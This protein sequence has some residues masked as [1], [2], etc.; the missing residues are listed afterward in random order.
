MRDLFKGVIL[1]DYGQFLSAGKSDQFITPC[2]EGGPSHD[3]P[4]YR[5]ISKHDYSLSH[6]L[7]ELILQ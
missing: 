7:R 6:A 3:L 4:H 1:S 2:M 5:D